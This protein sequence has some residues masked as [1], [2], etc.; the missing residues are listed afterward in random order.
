MQILYNQEK[1]FAKKTLYR[2][3]YMAIFCI[4]ADWANYTILRYVSCVKRQKYIFFQSPISSW[5]RLWYNIFS[6][7]YLSNSL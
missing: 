4:G 2:A 6:C 5:R 7:I 1:L 3:P